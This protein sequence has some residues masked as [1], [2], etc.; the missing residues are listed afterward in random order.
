MAFFKLRKA[1]GESQASAPAPES[2]DAMRRRARYR[3]AGAAILVLAAVVGFPLLF[4]NQPRPI[5]VDI[6]IDIPDKSRVKPLV[7][8]N[9]VTEAKQT[10]VAASGASTQAAAPGADASRGAAGA[11]AGAVTSAAKDSKPVPKEQQK[12]EVIISSSKPA[13]A[14]SAAKAEDKPVA[15][16]EP[17]P[18]PKVL[19]KPAEKAADKSTD[20]AG[21][22]AA[23]TGRF[24]VQFGAFTDSARAH[25][26]RMK[27]EKTGLKTYAQVVEGPE[28]K[29]FRVRVGPFEKRSDAEKAAEK[30]KKLDLPAAIL[31]L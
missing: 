1:A 26:A 15:K 4:D 17:K 27:V 29:K 9:P 2:V 21:D 8:S 12:E 28:G 5:A 16:S 7:A 25:E 13:A 30:I 11:V 19:A 3:L 31:G 22:K 14:P 10:E 6:P 23:A 18:E 24:I 20:K